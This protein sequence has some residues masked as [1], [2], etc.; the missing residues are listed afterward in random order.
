MLNVAALHVVATLTGFGIHY[1][2]P[3]CWEAIVT[4]TLGLN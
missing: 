2:Y 1:Q 3:I 4:L